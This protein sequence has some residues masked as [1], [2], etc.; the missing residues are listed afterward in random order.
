MISQISGTHCHSVWHPGLEGLQTGATEGAPNIY[1]NLQSTC[2][3]CLQELQYD[4]GHYIR[5]MGL[6]HLVRD[7]LATSASLWG[8][9]PP[10]SR[11]WSRLKKSSRRSP[12]HPHPPTNWDRWDG[13]SR[14]TQ[15]AL[16]KIRIP[17]HWSLQNSEANQFCYISPT[18]SHLIIPHP[19]L[20]N[21]SW[22]CY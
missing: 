19:P 10:Q 2:E 3:P 9:T 22:K 17:L 21:D 7:H 6:V 4:R 20:M 14:R 15:G 18:T 16:Q 11:S 12:Q 8:I 13:S 1:G 5:L